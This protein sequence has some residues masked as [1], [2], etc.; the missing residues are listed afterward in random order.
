MHGHTQPENIPHFHPRKDEFQFFRQCV[1]F[2]LHRSCQ[3]VGGTQT[4]VSRKGETYL[5]YQSHHIHECFTPKCYCP[6]HACLRQLTTAPHHWYVTLW[7]SM[8]S[9]SSACCSTF[10]GEENCSSSLE[11]SNKHTCTHHTHV[12]TTCTHTPHACTHHTH[13][14]THMH[15]PHTC[16]HGWSSWRWIWAPVQSNPF[17]ISKYSH[18]HITQTQVGWGFIPILRNWK[19][20]HTRVVSLSKQTS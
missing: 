20:T 19:H 3:S 6:Q 13:A 16:T 8:I 11:G 18:V 2:L 15:T 17:I 5:N 1:L 9:L 14:H 12:H 7:L 10:G 4:S